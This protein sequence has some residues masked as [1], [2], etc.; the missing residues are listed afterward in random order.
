MPEIKNTFLRGKMNKDLDERLIP[1][2]EYRDALNVE[3]STSDD[4]NVGTVKNILGNHRLEDIVDTNIFTCVGSIVDEKTNKLYWFISSYEKDAIVEYDY[5]KEES[6]F[7]F[8]DLYRGTSKSVLKF[9]NKIITGI[10]IIN[11]LLFWTDNVGEP[12]KINIDECKKNTVD[13]N[14]H[15][16]LSFENGSF[17]GFTIKLITDNTTDP[18]TL[19]Q[20]GERAWYKKE[21]LDALLGTNS[22]SPGFA[23]SQHVVRHYRDGEFLGL[24]NIVVFDDPADPLVA[25]NDLGTFLHAVDNFTDLNI[26]STAWRVDDIIFGN[27]VTIDIEERHITVIKPK[28]LTS[29]S[30]KINHEEVDANTIDTPNLFET[31]LPRFS[32]RYKYRDGEF[33]PFAPFTHP[34]F[35]A[36]YTKDTSVTTDSN[37]FYNRDTAYTEDD[38]FNKAMVNSIHS[39]ELT[40]FI[41]NQTPEDVVEIDILYKQE[42]S[43]MIFSVATIKHLDSRWHASGNYQG[44]EIDYGLGQSEDTD[45]GTYRAIGGINKGKYVVTSE[46][47]YA[48]LPEN[49]LLR[50][51][52]NVPKYALAQEITGN[53]IVYGNYTQGY[54]IEKETEILVSYGDRKN[55][56]I[57]FD[58]QGLPHIKSQRNYQLGV[59]YSDKYGR[60]TPVLTS[61]DAAVNVPWQDT[62]GKKNASRS[63][64]LRASVVNNFPEWVDSFKFFVKEISNEYYNLVM[65]R[66]WVT[67]TTYELDD[68]KG[69]LWLSFA[70]SDRNKVSEGDYIIL[71]KKI[72][73]GEE[74]IPTE[75]KF[76]II[77]IK[78]NA[79]NA[80]K[81]QLVNYGYI[82]QTSVDDQGNVTTDTLSSLL[83]TD[84]ETRIDKTVDTLK[85]DADAWK[86]ISNV[87]TSVFGQVPLETKEDETL[88]GPIRTR[89]LYVCWRRTTASDSSVSKKY[90]VIGGRKTGSVYV[91][92]LATEITK[93]DADIAHVDG[94]SSFSK[95]DLHPDLLFQVEKKELKDDENFSGKFF[96]CISKNEVADAIQGNTNPLEQ[97]QV[98]SKTSSWYWQDAVPGAGNATA[99][100]AS[101]VNYGLLNYFGHDA[102]HAGNDSIL[103]S[104]NNGGV[105]VSGDGKDLRLTDWH[106]P[107]S[108]IEA[109]FGPTF[110]IDSM[111]M[112]A[113][114][115]EASNYAKYCCMTW[116]SWDE[117]LKQFDFSWSYP[118]FKYWISDFPNQ[119]GIKD[120]LK[121]PGIWLDGNIISTSK[122]L[123]E[124]TNWSNKRIDGWVGGL[125]KV[126]RNEPASINTINENHINGLEGIV[127]T[128]DKHATG[129]RR[130]FSGLTADSTATG[131]PGVDTKTYSNNGETGRH[132]MHLS[133]FAPGRDL[134]DGDFSGFDPGAEQSLYGDDSWGANLQGIWGGGVFTSE[135][136]LD[137]FGSDNLDANKHFHL[138]MEGHYDVENNYQFLA[139]GPDVG[140]GYNNEYKELHERQW[141]PTF[142]KDGDPNNKILDFVRNLFP[143]AKFRFNKVKSTNVTDTVDEGSG[144]NGATF[145]LDTSYLTT[146]IKEGD[147]V[148]STGGGIPAG[149]TVSAV[150]VGSN[151]KEITLSVSVTLDDGEELTFSSPG[152][153][154]DEVY[155]IKKVSIKKLY[156]HTSWRKPYNRYLDGIGY[157]GGA[158]DDLDYWSVEY[159]ALKWLD[160]VDKDGL[161]DNTNGERDD[162]QNKIVQFGKSHNRRLCYIIELDK[163]PTDDPNFNPLDKTDVMTADF[164]SNNFCD[165]EFLDPVKSIF[166]SDLSKF[167]AV[168]ELDPKKQEVDLEIYF[169][170]SSNI[171]TKINSK[172]NE[173][174]APIGCDVEILN[175]TISD[176]CILESW[177]SS[178]I[179]VRPGFPKYDVDANGVETGID[180]SNM[181]FKFVRTDGSYTIAEVKDNYNVPDPGEPI[182]VVTE[183]ELKENIGENI[184]AGLS[185]YNSFSFGNG[186]ESNRI[187]DD[188]NAIFIRNGVRASSV[189]QETYEQETR[190]NSLIYSGIYNSNSSVNDLNQFI[191]AEKI[192]KDLNPTF[193]SIQ[194]LFQ[195]RVSLIAFCEDKVVSIVSN[196][197]TI[198]NADGNPQLIASNRVLGDANPFAGEYGISTNPESFAQESFRSYFADKQRG[199]VL[200]LSKDGLTPISKIGMHDWFRD[201][202]DK[203]NSLI[204]TYDSYKEDYNLTLSNNSFSQNLLQ[205][206]YLEVGGDPI[207]IDPTNKITNSVINNG[208]EFEYLYETYNVLDI[209]DASSTFT[210]DDFTADS[211]ALVATADITQHA[212]IPEGSLQ[213][214]V[215]EVLSGDPPTPAQSEVY[216][217][218]LVNSG[219]SVD[220]QIYG[221]DY[222]NA[223][224]TTPAAGG[225]NYDSGTYT[226]ADPNIEAT[227]SAVIG[228]TPTNNFSAYY[229]SAIPAA[230]D[231]GSGVINTRVFLIEGNT[232]P[233]YVWPD[234]G[235]G[236]IQQPSFD[237]FVNTDAGSVLDVGFPTVD[238]PDASFMNNIVFDR[239]ARDSYIVINNFGDN[240]TGNLADAYNAATDPDV[241][242]GSVFNGDEIHV[243]IKLTCLRTRMMSDTSGFG[244][245]YNA[246]ITYFGPGRNWIT[247]EITL[248][249]GS[250]AI[251][252]DYILDTSGLPTLANELNPTPYNCIHTDADASNWDGTYDQSYSYGESSLAFHGN[253]FYDHAKGYQSSSVVT[254]R[255]TKGYVG[256]RYHQTPALMQKN[257]AEVTLM[258]SFKF[259]DN[260]GDVNVSKVVDNLGIKIQNV[261]TGQFSYQG[262]GIF[263]TYGSNYHN[264][265]PKT[266]NPF[267]QRVLWNQLQDPLWG[268]KEITIRKGFGLET[269]FIPEVNNQVIVTH[270]VDA[271][272]PVDIPSWT[273]ITHNYFSLPTQT[274][275]LIAEAD[276]TPGNT[277]ITSAEESFAF[278]SDRAAIAQSGLLQNAD[279]SLSP[280]TTIDYVIPEG[281]DL[282]TEIDSFGGAIGSG[283]TGLGTNFDATTAAVPNVYTP[284]TET[285]NN[286]YIEVTN[287]DSLSS[288]DITHSIA[289]N[290]W[291]QGSWYL[292]DVEYSDFDPSINDGDVLVVGVAPLSSFVD[293]AVI[294]TDGIGVY[295][296]DAS[297]AHCK[298]VPTIRTEY[299]DIV[300]GNG[301]NQP[302]LRGIF[303]IAN[304][305]WVVNNDPNTFT[306]RTQGVTSGI[307]INRIIA[308][309]LDATASA[310]TVV[311]WSANTPATSFPTHSFSNNSMYYKNNS[312]CWELSAD[313]N[314]INLYHI[315]SQDISNPSTFHEGGWDLTFTV[316]VNP[317]T[318]NFSGSLG[319][320]IAISESGLF[321]G[322]AFSSIEDP[323]NYKISFDLNN[324]Q[325]ATSWIIF[326]EDALGDYVAYTNQ[327]LETAI[328]S[329]WNAGDA[330]N[331]I[332]FYQD[333]GET[334]AQEYS[335]NNIS[336]VPQEQSVLVGSTGSFNIN[337]FNLTQDDPYIYLDNV[338]NYFVFDDC[339]IQDNGVEFIS[340]TQQINDPVNLNDQYR[341]TFNHAITSGEISIYYYND[342]GYGFRIS[343]IDS[344]TPSNFNQVVAIGQDLWSPDQGIINGNDYSGYSSDLKNTF[345]IVASDNGEL[346]NGYIDNISMVKVYVSADTIDK[347]VTFNEGVNGWSS[348]KS[349][350]PEGGVSLSKKYFTF[351]NGALWQHYVPKL[352]GLTDYTDGDGFKIKYTAKEANNYNVFYSNSSYSS[353]KPVLNKEPS[354]VKTFNTIN[355]EGSQAFV[356]QPAQDQI[357][358][359][360]AAAWASGANING[361]QCSE[362]KTDLDSGS[363]VEFIKKEGKWFN[364]IKGTENVTGIDTSKFNVQGVGVVSSTQPSNFAPAAPAVVISLAPA[365]PALTPAPGGGANGGGGGGGGGYSGL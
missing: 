185:W 180:Y 64:Q 29:F 82:T 253:G 269:P 218:T 359:N 295:A 169:E 139:P 1:N 62:D 349:F 41:T 38:P 77:D 228:Q 166:L 274:W 294:D 109:K 305:S 357:T 155:T 249:D 300:T 16:Q 178:S 125:Q 91:L 40:D 339:P 164:D 230:F 243:K 279:P 353:V 311:D 242:H 191:A 112:A 233:S 134:H 86:D 153:T 60:E 171:P 344:S 9:P 71:K 282:T 114:Q 247:P 160:T 31:K 200:R 234:T 131:P 291:S 24:K 99:D 206:A 181:S 225:S 309:K 215:A 88:D 162:F 21:Q 237:I 288:S 203:Y 213:G 45:T 57:S 322:V 113:G 302:V 205:D 15:T 67:K 8:V 44:L 325:D 258:A 85:I 281:F 23:S 69:F 187:R 331:K 168:W 26:D 316:D 102:N 304:D 293:G 326:K 22:V 198:F 170:A 2:G 158:N 318:T 128:N 81:Y 121:T 192:T 42:Q 264:S 105:T 92:K 36:K 333:L 238:G 137:R 79:P 17:N 262:A 98:S 301:D 352:D 190:A 33:S 167:P 143:G 226:N 74:Q 216:S 283:T 154:D 117:N 209:N 136:G 193:G 270:A 207:T 272:P 204:G 96:V 133:F 276:G 248:L 25:V 265:P 312:L 223:A 6:S 360:N 273:E 141:D 314:G 123:P 174:F 46:N 211:N 307:K 34:V 90:K 115:S 78:N 313:A 345:V 108:G 75:N 338:N 48:V 297:F 159:T 239:A 103:A 59:V 310:G 30:V 53:R 335:I 266:T 104:N 324:S 252:S 259:T 10:N 66:A 152:E 27:N 111:H 320:V 354:I 80:I 358:I 120:T 142:N 14:T 165:I 221:A 127:T 195:R 182:K 254:F 50:S 231:Y 39:V 308:K 202:L 56:L 47:I 229:S 261:N 280:I 151:E 126:S 336:F 18:F 287:I 7:I 212:A 278:G 365:S 284:T 138:T 76:K 186:V 118:P 177:D 251:S 356:V 351:K 28:P 68:S 285:Y 35:N 129:P 4:S 196:K 101:A 55:K 130:W 319:G 290:P 323:G 334:D 116:A 255:E 241:F 93:I 240:G 140:Y 150:N 5:T 246:G 179:T 268:I 12:K 11:N 343:N 222:S 224:W 341:I 208:T 271:V 298:L 244:G 94:D 145:T 97:F 19:I 61:V 135:H 328:D 194:K 337:G 292:V 73:T 355:Y 100:A 257:T 188:F 348:F 70:S 256:L 20:E 245:S 172:T 144:V 176:F 214:A 306:L 110:F 346:I 13:I 350:T 340:I 317:V 124:N 201:N 197:D 72:G 275:G 227:I 260:N 89:N 65:D 329:P 122:L 52:D 289:N 87:G 217:T 163:N 43:P 362:I 49:Q 84:A 363:I 327:D 342:S 286:T 347:T 157:D 156:N 235:N 3:V 175:S 364:F 32:Y 173:L 63:L 299:G 161:D 95:S 220:G 219:S 54:D 210:W 236:V 184:L 321:R 106:S 37:V 119:A 183:F 147:I 296:G 149:T 132:F 107:W 263:A 199:A 189:T 332:Q 232:Y 330:G 58:T 51:Y 361:W 277:I 148:T 250:T 267:T 83:F 146:G 303:K 315:W